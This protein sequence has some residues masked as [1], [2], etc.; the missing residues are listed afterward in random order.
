MNPTREKM[1]DFLACLL[2]L[3]FYKNLKFKNIVSKKY[4]CL[5]NF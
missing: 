3:L 2:K 4:L 5:K 1:W